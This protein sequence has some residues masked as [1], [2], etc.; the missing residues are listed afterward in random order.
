MVY[1]Q[2]QLFTNFLAN[3]KSRVI[4]MI[5]PLTDAQLKAIQNSCPRSKAEIDQDLSIVRHWLDK[6][7]HLP[8]TS[9]YQVYNYTSR[10][11]FIEPLITSN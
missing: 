7:P 8:K 11:S 10:F 9:K 1:S 6:Q 2:G 4:I 3:S 5:V